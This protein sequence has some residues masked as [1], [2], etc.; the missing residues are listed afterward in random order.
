MK[1]TEHEETNLKVHIGFTAAIG[2][3]LLLNVVA[4][5]RFA[6]LLPAWFA[7]FREIRGWNV[8]IFLTL[9]GG[10]RIFLEAIR[11]LFRR[12]IAADLA[13][14]IAAVAALVIKEYAAAAEVIFIMLIGEGLEI[15]AVDRTRGAIRKLLDLSP[16]QARVRRDGEEK[17]VPIEDVARGDVVIVRP[18]ERIPVDGDVV[19]GR[20]SV[21]QS[22][23]TG[24]SMPA[25]KETGSDTFAGTINGPGRLEIEVTAVGE[26]TKLAEIIHLIEEAEESKAPVQRR[27]DRYAKFFV[28]AVIAIAILTYL[29]SK[30]YA[31]EGVNSIV[32]AVS[33][34]IVACP[35]ALILATP[36]A[37]VAALGRLARSGILVKGG[38]PL[39]AAGEVDAVVFDKTGTLTRG[40]PTIA[41]ITPFGDGAEKDVLSLAASVEQN[42]EHLLAE[43]IVTHAKE[44]GAPISPVEGF[45]PLPGLGVKAELD[46]KPLL[47]GGRKLMEQSEIDIPAQAARALDAM[48]QAGHTVVLVAHG[49]G[50][51]GAIGVEDTLREA[52]RETVKDLKASGIQHIS[53]LTG[54]HERTAA[55]I[56]RQAGIRNWSAGLLP[57]EKVEAIKRMQAEGRKVAMIG[58][59][60]NDAPSLATADVGIAMGGIG[61]DIAMNAADIVFTTDD[62]SRLAETIDV[63]RRTVSTI[64]SNLLWFA[65]AFNAVGVLAAAT[66]WATPVIAAVLHQVSSLLVCLNSLRLLVAGRF[67]ETRPGR[68]VARVKAF[69]QEDLPGACR[70]AWQRRAAIAE[71]L[72][73]LLVLLYAL[74]GFYAV[75]PGEVGIE[76]RFGRMVGGPTPPGLHYRLP[77]PMGRVDNVAVGRVHPLE[78]GLRR[79]TVAPGQTLAQPTAYEWGLK[80]TAG[81]YKKKN[82]EATM[83]TGD[84]VLAETT[85]VLHYRIVDPVSYVFHIANME[86]CLRDCAQRAIC[87]VVAETRLMS[88][89]AS[90]RA[91]IEKETAK[92]M[93]ALVDE[94]GCGV[95]I[96]RVLLQDVHPPV[97]V[98]PDFRAVSSAYEEMHAMINRGQATA[99]RAVATAEGEATALVED[100]GAYQSERVNLA[101]GRAGAFALIRKAYAKAPEVTGFR[102]FMET[103]ETSLA[104]LRKVI[105]DQSRK[106][107]YEI[108]LF[109]QRGITIEPRK[110]TREEQPEPTYRF[111][112]EREERVPE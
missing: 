60:I 106:G 75:Q 41:E 69:S 21:D 110:I 34:L 36:T 63:S 20:S 12:E 25:T 73:V 30:R 64:K 104:P 51:V 2:V 16:E 14:A 79:T 111:P 72:A 39:E 40:E 18:G 31:G 3:L 35:C 100:A 82:D 90:E 54:D 77:W 50:L 109:G 103:V 98:V 46:G 93:Q 56:A 6:E 19:Q 66:G 15:F 37:V 24:E 91:K 87:S 8:A 45:T 78:V 26:D 38:I 43:L 81:W 49:D 68:I 71:G 7:Y 48:A 44:Q 23:I 105:L 53:L 29:I 62:L 83:L 5:S 94:Y 96:E 42:S 1:H 76:R 101:E 59:G 65:L 4:S 70:G 107:K 84:E 97:D 52:A 10:Y 32:R 13:I 99:I 57:G 33:V 17:R 55:R 61:T 80:H 92:R 58:D 86:K 88:L 11:G 9:I 47:V 102:L 67:Y 95:R 22:P 28:P 27:V 108:Y 112:T 74:S 89:L 85:L